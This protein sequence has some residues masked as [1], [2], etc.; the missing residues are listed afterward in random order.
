MALAVAPSAPAAAA[1]PPL[2][3]KVA[4]NTLVDPLGRPVRVLGVNR[5]GTEF[6]CAQ[7]WGH[8]DGPTDA[9][10]LSKIGA[11]GANAVR[12]PLNESCWLGIGGVS[13]TWGGASYRTA[14]QSY[15]QRL[16][17]AGMLVILDLHWAAPGSALATKQI[18]MADADHAPAFW[19]SVATTFRADPAVIFDLYN[20]PYDISWSCWRDG[21]TTS[22]G[23]RA[24]GMQ[25]LVDAVR[26]TGALQPLLLNGIQYGGD[27]SQW[28][29]YAPKDPA[30]QLIAGA[31][32]YDFSGCNTVSCWDA[33]LAPV[34][35]QVPMITGEVGQSNCGRD[36]LDRYLDWADSHGVSYTPWTWNTW[37]CNGGPSLIT[38]YD[39]T[40][41]GFGIGVRERL[42]KLAAQSAAAPTASPRPP[43]P[44]VAPT[45]PAPTVA[46]TRPAPT[47][48]PTVT[49]KV[50]AKKPIR[51]PLRVATVTRA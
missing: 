1:A 21:C 3:V 26:S 43:A 20:E 18:Q 6:A 29:T 42:L 34:A 50:A 7:G 44:T 28:L 13:T 31:H 51:R 41:T 33:T 30:G 19:Q 23:Y 24:A 25:S 2:A 45:L 47:A 4:G 48:S 5:A 9:A 49:P 11:W 12:V 14:I 39:G 16:H 35:A 22:A 32:I 10:A 36:W 46:P 38:N 8:F 17:E 27:L 40:P 15:V 37:D